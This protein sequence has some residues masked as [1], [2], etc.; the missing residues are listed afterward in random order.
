[1]GE[2][3]GNGG[4]LGTSPGTCAASTLARDTERSS[5]AMPCFFAFECRIEFR[6]R[7]QRDGRDSAGGVSSL[8]S[9]GRLIAPV[10][11]IEEFRFS[12]GPQSSSGSVDCDLASA[13]VIIAM[14]IARNIRAA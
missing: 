10:S 3:A 4:K 14:Q 12:V 1:L 6:N 13:A 8:A 7:S 2:G 5:F 9:F 11:G